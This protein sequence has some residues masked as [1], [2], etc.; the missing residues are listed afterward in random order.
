MESYV[1]ETY[2]PCPK[3]ASKQCQSHVESNWMSYI[4]YMKHKEF[5]A[6]LA[7]SY[8]KFRSVLDATT[9]IC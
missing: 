2:E 9:D 4:S 6:I 5:R 3:Q 8:K 7:C 1:T